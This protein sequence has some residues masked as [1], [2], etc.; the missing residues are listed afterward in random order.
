M[1]VTVDARQPQRN[2]KQSGGFRRQLEMVGIGAAH[3][4]GQTRKGGIRRQPKRFD[5]YVEGAPILPMAPEHA[6][7]DNVE[8]LG[9]L[10]RSDF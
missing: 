6:L 10:L 4:R 7:I 2:R 5:H 9:L 8:R 1:I 3:D